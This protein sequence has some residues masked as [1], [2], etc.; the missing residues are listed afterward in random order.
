[1]L[2]TNKVNLSSV[3]EEDGSCLLHYQIKKIKLKVKCY[4]RLVFSMMF[5]CFQG[6][7]N[8]NA[9]NEEFSF[10]NMPNSAG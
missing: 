9:E 2:S 5:L 6:F 4:F 3:C 1:M 10:S 8:K 7:F